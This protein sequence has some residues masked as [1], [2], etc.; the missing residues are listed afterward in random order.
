MSISNLAVIIL[1][2]NEERN[3]SYA[4]DSVCGWAGEVHVLD[5]GST[6]GTCALALARG[7][8]VTH[9]AFVSYP[10][11]RNF[12]LRELPIAAEWVLFLDADEQVTPELR[13]EISRL[14]QTNPRENG[15]LIK[16]KLIW[17]GRWIRRGY[18]PVWLHRLIRRNEAYYPDRAINEHVRVEGII[19]KLRFDL[20]HE[21]HK[22]IAVWIARHNRYAELEAR[23][24]LRMLVDPPP[25]RFWN[26]TQAERTT[27]IR[28]HVWRRLPRLFRPF[29]Y[30]F[31]RYFA[32]G[33]FLDG[34]PGFVYHFL[35]GLW[36]QFLIDLHC[37]DMEPSSC[38]KTGNPVEVAKRKGAGL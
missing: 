9:H 24:F 1:T 36:Y 30:F 13:Q 32:R 7:C 10:A 19:G 22:G 26:A 35:H 27:W 20:I 29:L 3:L 12:A 34:L 2:M 4:L 37:L 21:D 14:L 28:L 5:S 25:A 17:M 23:E 8:V 33:G 11:Q 15:F 16:Y 6:D 18:Y 31:Y 38:L